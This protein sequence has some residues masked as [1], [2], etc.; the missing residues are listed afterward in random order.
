VR[1]VAR[2]ETCID[3]RAQALAEREHAGRGHQQRDKRA[4]NAPSVGREEA[5]QPRELRDVA[6]GGGMN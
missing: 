2:T 4:S 3:H 5:R 6:L 1:R